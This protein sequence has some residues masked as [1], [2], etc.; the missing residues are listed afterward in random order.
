MKVY[1][2]I[3]AWSHKP[4]VAFKNKKDVEDWINHY[5]NKRKKGEPILIYHL[6][7]GDIWTA[8]EFIE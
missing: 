8:L 5:L 4:L 3:G 1:V 2:V 7:E 6:P